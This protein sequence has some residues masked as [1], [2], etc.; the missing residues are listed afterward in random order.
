MSQYLTTEEIATYCVEQP[1]VT[2]MEVK[3]ASDLI[4]GY[5][6]KSFEVKDV[7][8][9]VAV[10]GRHRGKLRFSPVVELTS[11][12]EVIFTDFGISKVD[13]SLDYFDLDVE[14]D[15]Y[16]TFY[17]PF[18]VMYGSYGL[19]RPTNGRKLEVTYKYGYATIPEDIK[20]VCAMLA[21]NIRQFQSFAGVKKMTTLDY[22]VEMGNASFFTDDMQSILDRYK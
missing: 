6:K 13:A 9:S 7:T 14:M 2:A 19:T 20:T 17:Q 15:G 22:S 11:A 10:N 16:F 12:K 5:L 1:G 4:D 8:E 21:Q 3:I 18:P